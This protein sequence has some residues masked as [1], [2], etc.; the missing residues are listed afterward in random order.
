MVKKWN[1][2][3]PK[4]SGDM[5][6]YHSVRVSSDARHVVQWLAQRGIH[7]ENWVK[8]KDIKYEDMPIANEILQ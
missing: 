4:L 3:I 7:S 6:R 8:F 1:V 5:T 2:T